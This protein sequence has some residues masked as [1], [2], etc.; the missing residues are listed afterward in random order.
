MLASLVRIWRYEFLSFFWTLF[1]TLVYD[2]CDRSIVSLT[3]ALGGF[4]LE[5]VDYIPM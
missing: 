5:A 4:G 2:V 3:L 1:V